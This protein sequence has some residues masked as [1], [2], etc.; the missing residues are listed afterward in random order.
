MPFWST[1]KIKRNSVY[2]IIIPFDEGRV[3]RGAYELSLSR[4]ALT[5]G[6]KK[7]AI[8]SIFARL[9]EDDTLEIPAGQFALLYSEECV[10]VPPK[11]LGFISI[12]AKVKWQ[13]LINVSG[14][15]VDPGFRGKLKFSVYNAGTRPIFLKYGQPLFS[16]WFANFEEDVEDPYEGDHKDQDGI[17][18]G[19]KREMSDGIPS[20]AALDARLSR[21]ELHNKILMWVAGIIVFPALIAIA[22]GVFNRWYT[23]GGHTPPTSQSAAQAYDSSTVTQPNTISKNQKSSGFQDTGSSTTSKTPSPPLAP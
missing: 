19:D 3:S 8:M 22:S 16:M 9:K 13:G 18:P 20:P 23:S 17:T 11:V 14:F 1:Q 21:M 2:G 10:N 15:H 6:G 5:S 12:K 7:S 4:S